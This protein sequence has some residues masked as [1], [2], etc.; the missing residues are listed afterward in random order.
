ML[1][2]SFHFLLFLP[3]VLVLY[4]VINQKFRFLFLLLASFY[5]YAAWNPPFLLL[6]VFS[7]FVDFWCSNKIFKSKSKKQ[8]KWY[9]TLSLISNFGIL[10]T[11]KYL[12]FIIGSVNTFSGSVLPFTD[13][14]LPM[15][16]SFYTFQTVSYTIDVYHEKLK[17]ENNYLRFCVFVTFFPQLVAGPIER[18]KDLLPQLSKKVNLKPYNIVSGFLLILKGLFKKVVIADR[19][20]LFVNSVYEDPSGFDA[21]FLIIATVFFAFQIYCDFSGYS[22]MAIGI[23]RMMGIHLSLN[24]NRPYISQSVAEFWR[25]WHI[26][27]ST[28]FRDYVYIPLGGGRGLKW[29]V[30]Y[31]L[32]ITFLISGLWHG[33][34]W[35]FLIWGA[36]HGVLLVVNRFL[37]FDFK[38]SALNVAITFLLTCIGWVFFRAESFNEAITVFD[39]ISKLGYQNVYDLLYMIKS[40]VSDLTFL[41]KPINI[42]YGKIY[43]QMT[44]ADFIISIA[45]I[46][47]LLT[48]EANEE[49][50]Y[51]LFYRSHT[52]TKTFVLYF[53]IMT[54]AVLG[55][56]NSTQFIYF[57]F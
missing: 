7:A 30:S 34:N 37:K 55:I 23:A 1:F 14:V 16:I 12:D 19:L 48:F 25:R 10:F 42:D 44:V 33:A 35:T 56:F 49:K 3:V 21:S 9:L 8:K 15:G 52:I 36:Y 31:N 2:N 32:F 41:L 6:I 27:L 18:A 47:V 4:Y 26:T 29:R 13:L 38:F 5:F 20:A 28:W 24:F 54:I 11:F 53:F 50:L 51:S 22:D 57:Q 43:L 17:P 40:S 46:L 45:V 39:G